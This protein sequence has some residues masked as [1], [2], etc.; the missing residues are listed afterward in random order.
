M[1]WLVGGVGTGTGGGAGAVGDRVRQ[2]QELVEAAAQR[3]VRRLLP[4]V[5]L[6]EREGRVRCGRL[7][8]LVGERALGERQPAAP[9]TD[10]SVPSASADGTKRPNAS[11][12][13]VARAASSRRVL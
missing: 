1:L 13:T 5:P 6:A 9:P 10:P 7:A 8:Q 3:Q 2:P 4:L 11:L 12:L